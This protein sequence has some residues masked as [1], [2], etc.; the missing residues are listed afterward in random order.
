MGVCVCVTKRDKDVA[1]TS[2]SQGINDKEPNHNAYL[3]T[4]MLKIILNIPLSFCS[5]AQP[6][7]PSDRSTWSDRF[8]VIL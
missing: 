4:P 5:G 6:F 1:D 3:L 7:F 2:K 8:G